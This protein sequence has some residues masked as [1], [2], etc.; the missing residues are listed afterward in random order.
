MNN[1]TKQFKVAT[2]VNVTSQDVAGLYPQFMYESV[3]RLATGNPDVKF[4]VT[5]TPF[6]MTTALSKQEATVS[7]VFIAFVA[8][9][10][11]VCLPACSSRVG[12]FPRKKSSPCRGC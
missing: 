3:I 8:G 7:G 12:L 5:N 4:K 6:P 9:S 1:S 11:A 10:S 2:F